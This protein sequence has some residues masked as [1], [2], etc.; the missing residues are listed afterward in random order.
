M[1]LEAGDGTQWRV[2]RQWMPRYEGRGLRERW[3]RSRLRR[4]PRRKKPGVGDVLEFGSGVGDLID[5]F[6][7][8]FLVVVS[9]LPL[10]LAALDVA[11]VA[12]V[13]IA[14]II[15]RVL[16]RRPWTIEAESADGQR[17]TRLVLGWRAG[18]ERCALLRVRSALRIDAGPP[19]AK[20][21]RA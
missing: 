13:A 16:F 2:S 17:V 21:S 8:V 12:V 6:F 11:L 1:K 15:G 3:T 18:V 5:E 14:G 19:P 4:G 9:G 10:L 20:L 7:V